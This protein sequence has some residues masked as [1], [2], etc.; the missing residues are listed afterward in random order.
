L[1]TIRLPSGGRE[2]FGGGSR[3]KSLF[4]AKEGER[5]SIDY[6]FGVICKMGNHQHGDYLKTKTEKRRM[7]QKGNAT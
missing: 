6:S 7:E 2:L 1:L 4:L 3:A 5:G